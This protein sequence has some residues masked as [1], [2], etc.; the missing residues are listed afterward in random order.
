[1]RDWLP[2][3]PYSAAWIGGAGASTD[4]IKGGSMK[5][6]KCGGKTQVTDSEESIS[7]HMVMRRRQCPACGYRFK[8]TETF[9]EDVKA[10]NDSIRILGKEKDR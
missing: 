10:R 4:S 1:M 5:C 6:K 9:W 3:W 8:T 7:G 2:Y